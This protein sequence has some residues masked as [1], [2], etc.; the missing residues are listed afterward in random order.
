MVEQAYI[1]GVITGAEAIAALWAATVWPWLGWLFAIGFTID[2]VA[3][4]RTILPHF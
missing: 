4:V 3:D 1:W 2:V